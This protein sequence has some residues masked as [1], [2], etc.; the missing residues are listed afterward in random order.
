MMRANVFL[1]LFLLVLDPCGLQFSSSSSGLLLMR[2]EERT[3]TNSMIDPCQI[4]DGYVSSDTLMRGIGD[5]RFSQAQST[6]TLDI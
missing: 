3:A 1:S 5:V 4:L 6:R 2:E